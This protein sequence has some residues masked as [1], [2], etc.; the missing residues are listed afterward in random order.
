MIEH[1]VLDQIWA[2]Y[3]A[4]VANGDIVLPPEKISA[5][6]PYPG[7]FLDPHLRVPEL[8]HILRHPGLLRW[9]KVL[10]GREPVPF[11]TITS[12]KGSQQGAHSDA[13]HMTTYPLGYLSAAWIAFEDIHPDCGPLVYYP[14]SHRLPYVFSKDLGIPERDFVEHG[15]HSYHERY[16]P[17]IQKLIADNGLEP[18]YFHAGKGDAPVWPMNLL[19]GGSLRRNVALSRHAV[20]C[21]FFVEGAFAYHDLA[22]TQTRPYASTC[23]LRDQDR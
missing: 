6:D 21:H 16:E 12:H 15:Y 4:A 3:E 9:L 13:I 5:D 8:C 17:S 23:L 1:E 19:H 7:R 11:Q 18:H 22:G 14:G 2:A 10:M 20:V